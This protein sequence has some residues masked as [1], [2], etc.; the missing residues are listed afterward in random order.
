MTEGEKGFHIQLTPTQKEKMS[1]FPYGGQKE[2]VTTL[3]NQLLSLIEMNSQGEVLNA[4]SK[5]EIG[6]GYSQTWAD[7][8]EVLCDELKFWL[9]DANQPLH[10]SDAFGKGMILVQWMRGHMADHGKG[11]KDAKSK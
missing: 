2:A 11:D 7:V 4:L 10:T 3:I 9:D 6:I 1:Q 8:I 5:G